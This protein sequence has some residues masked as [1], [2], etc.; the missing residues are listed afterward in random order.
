MAFIMYADVPSAMFCILGI[1]LFIF[2]LK[3]KGKL[4][5]LWLVLS[6]FFIAWASFTKENAIILLIAAILTTLLALKPKKAII[7]LGIF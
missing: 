3:G 1:T 5:Y 4:K 2:Y 7:T 6:A